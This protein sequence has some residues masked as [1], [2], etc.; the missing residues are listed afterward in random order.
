MPGLP[1]FIAGLVTVLLV[2]GTSGRL[3]WSWECP[4]CGRG[5]GGWI[6]D[7]M[8]DFCKSCGLKAYRRPSEIDQHFELLPL[9]PGR[10]LDPRVRRI[11]SLLEIASGS[12][13]ILASVWVIV[14][15]DVAIG[16]WLWIAL[17]GF[18][19]LGI[20]GGVLLW[21][22]HLLGYEMSEI[23]QILQIAQFSFVGFT[24]AVVAGPQLLV[25]Y[26]NGGIRASAGLYA[27]LFLG[28]RGDSAFIAINVAAIVV[29][30]LL[31]NGRSAVQHQIAESGTSTL[32]GPAGQDAERSG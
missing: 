12:L 20:A 28:Q 8:P 30:M 19:V 3:L 25:G 26:W 4:R 24:F 29:L 31:R 17:Q 2:V 7:P 15:R 6:G 32:K 9:R 27:S 22:D 18:A 21:R 11:L 23:L 16:G 5:F 14:T 1:P 13:I 10:T